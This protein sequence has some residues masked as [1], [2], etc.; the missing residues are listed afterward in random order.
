VIEANAAV[1]A[2]L[3]LALLGRPAL[4]DALFNANELLYGHIRFA[5]KRQQ[6]LLKF[7]LGESI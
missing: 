2:A 6:S 5:L 3:S 7:A 4:G 1:T